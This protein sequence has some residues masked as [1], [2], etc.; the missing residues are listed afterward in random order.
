MQIL[1]RE[2]P[3]NHRVK[4]VLRNCYGHFDKIIPIADSDSL[5]ANMPG[6]D[7][8]QRDIHDSTRKHTNHTYRAPSPDSTKRLWQRVL[9]TDLYNMV[10]TIAT[11]NFTCTFTPFRNLAIVDGLVSTHRANSGQLFITGGCDN[12]KSTQHLCKL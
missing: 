9:T 10:N 3:I 11:C 6:H 12:H 2:N 7:R 4:L 8:P 5:Q 1:E